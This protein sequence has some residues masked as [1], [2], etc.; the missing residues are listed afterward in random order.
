MLH[1]LALTRLAGLCL[2]D[3]KCAW[4]NDEQYCRFLPRALLAQVRPRGAGEL[5]VRSVVRAEGVEPSWAYAQ[6]IFVPATAF[7]AAT[8]G[9]CGLDYTF[10][11]A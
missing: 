4:F 8:D 11:V 7:A 2:F 3:I 10:A 6:R 5:A 9:V 1:A